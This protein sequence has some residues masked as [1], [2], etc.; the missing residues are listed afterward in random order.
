[1]HTYELSY[2]DSAGLRTSTG[3]RNVTVSCTEPAVSENSLWVDVH[4][5]SL[6]PHM[7]A[8]GSHAL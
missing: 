8:K 4:Y 7:K 5:L 3:L 6:V 1:M 2:T